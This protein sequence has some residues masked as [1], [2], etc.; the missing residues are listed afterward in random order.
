MPTDLELLLARQEAGLDALTIRAQR[1]LMREVEAARKELQEAIRAAGPVDKLRLQ[2]L[3]MRLNPLFAALQTRLQDQMAFAELRSTELGLVHNTAVVRQMAPLLRM[4][5]AE[6]RMAGRLADYR[7]LALYNHSAANLTNAM[8][9]R[10]Q[11]QIVAGVLQS[12]SEYQIAQRLVEASRLPMHRAALIARMETSRAYNQVASEMAQEMGPKWTREIVEVNDSKNHPF[13][14]AAHGQRAKPG[15]MFKVPVA[16]VEAAAAAM[17]RPVGAVLW[18][19]SGAHYVGDNLPAH[20]NERGRIVA[21]L[22]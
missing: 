14:R 11:S 20:Y 13:S 1:R 10:I 3:L 22:A 8:K 12:E 21:V 6:I 7:S 9:A 5:V 17:G 18:R 16:E 19:R 2:Q 4:G 15:R